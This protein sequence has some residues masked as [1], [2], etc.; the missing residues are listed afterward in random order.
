MRYLLVAGGTVDLCQL[1]NVYD[2]LDNPCVIGIDKGCRYL[3]ELGLPIHKAIGDFD[4]IGEGYADILQYCDGIERLNPIKDDTDTEHAVHF[5]I[6][7][8]AEEVVILGGTGSRLDHTLS[9]I[10]LLKCFADKGIDAYILN[11]NNRIYMKKGRIEFEKTKVFGKYISIFPYQGNGMIK[12]IEGFKYEARGLELPLNTSRGVSNELT[13]D[14]GY[15][16]TEDYIVIMET[17]D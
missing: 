17:C 7:Q 10:Y 4:S 1:K 3:Y 13:S 14:T 5:G 8:G 15:I 2:S 9:S 16:E 11:K 6:E 12:S